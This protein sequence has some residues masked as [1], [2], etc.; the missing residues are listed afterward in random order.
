M[1]RCFRCL[2]SPVVVKV[3]VLMW[4]RDRFVRGPNCVL[5]VAPARE[6][7][8]IIATHKFG[9]LPSNTGGDTDG[10]MIEM[11]VY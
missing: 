6:S 11:F 8:A 5:S 2:C 10:H 3:L 4:K 7:E 1:S 9:K